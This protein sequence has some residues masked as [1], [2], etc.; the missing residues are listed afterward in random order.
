MELG[1]AWTV[2][3]KAFADAGIGDADLDASILVEHAT[4][5]NRIDR[6]A[7]PGMQLDDSQVNALDALMRR[8]LGGE[9]VYRII[10]RRGFY[11]LELEVSGDTLEPRPDTEILVD[12]VCTLSRAVVA[13]KGECRLLDLGTGTGAIAL[14]VLSEVDGVSAVATD[15]SQGALETAK[16]NAATHRLASRAAFVQSDWFSAVTGRFDIIASNPPYIPSGEI[17]GLAPEVRDHDPRSA[18]DGG[19]DGLEA[20]RWIAA[21]ARDF[22][23]PAGCV[24]VE[25]GYDQKTGVSLLFTNNGYRHA[26]SADDLAGNHRVLVFSL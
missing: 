26:A 18:L 7:L 20:Y 2:M 15:I 13:R 17:G 23:N 11:G 14:A 24:A 6:I 9:P 21:G 3:R 12:R 8:R 16:R 5:T 25:T 10:G 4:G 1:E 19:P 22:L